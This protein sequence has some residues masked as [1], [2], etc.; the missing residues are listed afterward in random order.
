MSYELI[1]LNQM[2]YSFL[3]FILIAGILPAFAQNSEQI[4]TTPAEIIEPVEVQNKTGNAFLSHLS[5]AL[6]ASTLGGGIQ[7]AT[8]INNYFTLRAGLDYMGYKTGDINIALDDPDGMFQ[9]SLG[10]TPDYKMKGKL[11][12][13]HG[14]VLVDFHPTKGIFHLTA[15]FFVGTNKIKA[16]GMLVDSNG[17]KAELKPGESW[18]TINLEGHQLEIAD[19]NLNAELQ[20]GKVIKPY[21]GLG[22]GRAI[23][24]KRVSFKFELGAMYQGDYSL[25][26]NGKKLDISKDVSENFDDIDTYTNLLKWWPMLNFQISYKIF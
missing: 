1:K 8:P 12:L 11:N 7:A 21:F 25:K 18:P 24:N 2:K 4:T 3:F 22:L 19:A 10:Y 13:T 17:E 5:I 9:Q 20:L 6:R 15:G 23:A 26:Q 16:D 14:N